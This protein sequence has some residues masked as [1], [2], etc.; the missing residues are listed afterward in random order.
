M[1]DCPG[2]SDFAL[3]NFTLAFP[4]RGAVGGDDAF[5]ALEGFGDDKAK[6][7]GEGWE[8]EDVTPV[9]DFLE[10]VAKGVGYI[11]NAEARRRRVRR[12]FFYLPDG[13]FEILDAFQWVPAAEVE[14]VEVFFDRI[15]RIYKIK[16]A[17]FKEALDVGEFDGWAAVVEI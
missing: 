8:N 7:L 12:V 2:G 9:P 11:F 14:K 3:F 17:E 16:I 10:L 6:V 1:P 15:N 4:C 5:A 13:S